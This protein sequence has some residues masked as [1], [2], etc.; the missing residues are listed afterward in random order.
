MP[1]ILFLGNERETDEV[2]YYVSEIILCQNG[3]AIDIQYLEERIPY[4]KVF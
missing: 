2:L 3:I 4:K 1:I